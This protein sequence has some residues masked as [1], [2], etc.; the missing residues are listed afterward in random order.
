MKHL[1]LLGAVALSLTAC[2]ASP[3]QPSVQ[4][5]SDAMADNIEAMAAN[6]EAA[7]NDQ[8]N[9]AEAELLNGAEASLAS[10]NATLSNE[11]VSANMQ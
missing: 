9:L 7:A 3:D 5:S 4:N 1:L 11:V 6:M 8:G 10:G 2:G